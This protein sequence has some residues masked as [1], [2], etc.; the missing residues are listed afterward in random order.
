MLNWLLI[1][2]PIA[3]YLEFSQGN[4][5][6]IFV[7]S[8]LAILPLAGLMGRATEELAIRAG[9]AVGGLLNAT[10]GN[11]TELII[12]FFALKAGKLDVVKASITGSILGN[13]LLVLGLAVFLGGLKHKTQV[14]NQKNAGILTSLLTLSVI[15]L[16]IPAVFDLASVNFAHVAQP[17]DLDFKVS[18]AAAI[19]LILIYLGNV[20]FSL[21]T[22]KDMLS[23]HDDE[24]HEAATWSVPMAVGVLL[25]STV[26]VGFM[27]EFL[28][29]SL[30]EASH[31]LGLSEFFVGI[32]LI[33]IIGNA[34]EHASAVMF[35]LK[36]KMDLAVTIAVGSTIQVALLVAPLL[37]LLGLTVGQ[38]M[39]LVMH[40]PLELIAVAAG[41]VIANSIARD[42]ESNW[43][44]GLMLLGV[45]VLLAFAFFYFPTVSA[46]AVH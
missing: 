7:A 41:I 5:V 26:A 15:G 32:I 9:S 16:L 38:K 27:S 4:A 29:G 35:A 45:Y 21:V 19:V 13:I 33:P 39:D 37:V 40:N 31:A 36:N 14:F 11:A 8:M 18:V 43:L 6:W 24:E 46:A 30:E 23:P 20:Y 3:V 1:F 34:A 12:A 2:I 25:A 22:H 42:G 44:E 17:A 28:V 10:F